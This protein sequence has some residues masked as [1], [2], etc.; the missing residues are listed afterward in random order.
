MKEVDLSFVCCFG[1]SLSV[2]IYVDNNAAASN[3][4]GFVSGVAVMFG[5]REAN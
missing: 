3:D 1:L 4:R 5:N 2:H